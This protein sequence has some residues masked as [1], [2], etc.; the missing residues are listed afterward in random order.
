MIL[1]CQ[2]IRK[3]GIFKNY[4]KTKFAYIKTRFIFFDYRNSKTKM[5]WA[6]KTEGATRRHK[7]PRSKY[8]YVM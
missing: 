5:R 3:P 7:G 2:K 1:Y 6:D 8:L 4:R